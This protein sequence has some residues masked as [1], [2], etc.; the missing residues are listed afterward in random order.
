[1]LTR[2]P[3]V[4]MQQLTLLVLDGTFAIC[5]LGSDAPVPPWATA[6][7]FLSITRTADELSIVCRQDSVPEGI[8]CE[9]GWRCLR[10][11]GTI[12]FSVVGLL[13][14]V[15]LPLAEAGIS[16]FAISTFDTDYLLVKEKD[17]AASR[18]ALRRYLR[19]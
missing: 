9:R 13:A 10:V 15:V 6:G 16:V 7:Q 8:P 5:K 14:S 4:A 18:E 2:E 19:T 17:L 12:P 3:E 1:M 11:A